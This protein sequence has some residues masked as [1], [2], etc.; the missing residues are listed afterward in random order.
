MYG[1]YYTILALSSIFLEIVKM[2]VGLK[3]MEAAFQENVERDE[4]VFYEKNIAT[5]A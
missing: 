5:S 2:G 1:Q 3:H 4:F